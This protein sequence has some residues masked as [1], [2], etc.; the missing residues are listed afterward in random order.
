MAKPAFQPTLPAPLRTVLTKVHRKPAPLGSAASGA[1]RHFGGTSWRCSQPCGGDGGDRGHLSVHRR[2]QDL[3]R[4]DRPVPHAG[5]A[6]DGGRNDHEL[7]DSAV[8]GGN[9]AHDQRQ[10]GVT[11]PAG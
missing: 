6:G 7:S 9:L 11:D 4:R 2:A 10:L 8:F 3:R 1:C 5:A